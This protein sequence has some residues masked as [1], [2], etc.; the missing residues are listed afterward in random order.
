[1]VDPFIKKNK[2]LLVRKLTISLAPLTFSSQQNISQTPTQ[3]QN[4]NTSM[5]CHIS[6]SFY[7]IVYHQTL[8]C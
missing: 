8:W 4:T 3:K 1:M 2:K 5:W 6:Y 7:D